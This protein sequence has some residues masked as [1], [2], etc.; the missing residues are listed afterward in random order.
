MKIGSFSPEC[1]GRNDTLGLELVVA[2]GTT[3]IYLSKRCHG[4]SL[5]LATEPREKREGI[6]VP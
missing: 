2:H 6:S 5:P 3:K 4:A 1:V